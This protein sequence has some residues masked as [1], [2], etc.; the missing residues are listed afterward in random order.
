MRGGKSGTWSLRGTK[1]NGSDLGDKPATQT[2]TG[3]EYITSNICAVAC[4][5]H[6]SSRGGIKYTILTTKTSDQTRQ[7]GRDTLSLRASLIEYI[8]SNICAVACHSH[9]SS[10]GGINTILTTKTSDQ[11]RQRGRATLSLRA[12]LIE[13]IT[14]NICAV[15]NPVRGH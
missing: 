6:S 3:I 8:T 7:R 15:A 9:S 11:T 13:Y 12:S 14:S 1:V 5:S 10:R 2:A 4:H